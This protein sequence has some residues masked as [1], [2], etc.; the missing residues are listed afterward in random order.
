MSAEQQPESEKPETM[1]PVA[2]KRG[3]RPK[4]PPQEPKRQKS[5]HSYSA[6][7]IIREISPKPE[8]PE[9]EPEPEPSKAEKDKSDP[10][11]KIEESK[12]DPSGDETSTAT[13]T[14][15]AKDETL[16]DPTA[17]DVKP[18]KDPN[19]SR[20]TSNT[21]TTN[22]IV[23]GKRTVQCNICKKRMTE[24][25]L[26][27]HI[28]LLHTP[29]NNERDDTTTQ[30]KRKDFKCETCGKSYAIKYTYEQHVKTHTEGRPK[31]PECDST[32]ASLFSLFRHRAKAH[33]LEHNY[34]THKCDICEKVFF[35]TS[36]LNLHQ[37]RH[38][39]VKE[40]KCH[41]C[42]KAFSVKGNLRI[43]MR[44]HAKEKLYKCDICENL[45]SHPYSLVSHRRI[46]TNDFPFKCTECDTSYRSK[47]QLTSHMNVH[48]DNRP[49]KCTDCEKTFRSRTAFKMHQDQHQGI[50][51]FACQFCER[52]FQCLANRL[53]HERR[54]VGEKKHK[55]DRCEKAFIEKQELK[56]HLKVHD[57]QAALNGPM[58]P[59][60]NR[61]SIPG[62]S[63]A[64]AVPT[65]GKQ[66]KA[67]AAASGGTA[68]PGTPQQKIVV[69]LPTVATVEKAET[70]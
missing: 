68:A 48:S 12:K 56:N 36:E 38:S 35:S 60:P 33:N 29:A 30:G 59:V 7:D 22:Q 15:T 51:R 14:D 40:Y 9:P 3:R 5:R 11:E 39:A 66:A 1:T 6:Q 53:K 65:K 13:G 70:Q 23:N 43:H 62:L 46:H 52:K 31:C 37:Q 16:K 4:E 28:R 24:S 20:G 58:A 2:K 21:L 64:S 26:A 67:A 69:N 18:S 49:F 25:K 42:K 61:D 17:T 50:K 41:E 47:H 8:Y 63:S 34:T 19:I 27:N 57:K 54:H 44:T 10:S 55:C 45:F 32:F